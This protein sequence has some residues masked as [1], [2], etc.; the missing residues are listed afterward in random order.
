MADPHNDNHHPFPVDTI[1]HAIVTDPNPKV[2]RLCLEF[3][4]PRRKRIFAE[5][6]NFLG[7]PAL[8]LFVEVPELADGGRREFKNV[9]HGRWKGLQAEVLLYLRPGNRRFIPPFA[10][11]SNI[12]TIF[13]LL[14]KVVVF[15]RNDCGHGL[16]STMNDHSFPPERGTV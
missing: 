11:F 10:C 5:R 4:A 13:Q 6:G 1:D 3:L 2:V 8:K 7:D 14:K 9:T 12:D 15:D 16:F